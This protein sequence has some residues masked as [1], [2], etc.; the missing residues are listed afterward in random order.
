MATVH[1]TVRLEVETA[2][3]VD[4]YAA[5]NGL[6]RGEA[7]GRLLVAGLAALDAA[8]DAEE[9][10]PEGAQ[11]ACEAVS[12]GEGTTTPAD[13]S[14]TVAALVSSLQKQLE[15]KDAQIGEL[16]RLQDQGQQLQA[17]QAQQIKALLPGE[18]GEIVTTRRTW[19][20]RLGAW[21]AGEG[22]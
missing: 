7:M 2:E 14:D 13:D 10:A 15:V 1:R 4:Q 6:K 17:A 11:G 3:R 16:L 19:R 9:V 8:D 5:A 20:Q 12:P 21:I 22:R 18:G